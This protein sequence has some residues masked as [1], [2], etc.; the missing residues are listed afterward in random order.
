[1][2]DGQMQQLGEELGIAAPFG[3]VG[4]QRGKAAAAFLLP[5]NKQWVY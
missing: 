2:L 1:M 5:V 3:C 4:Y